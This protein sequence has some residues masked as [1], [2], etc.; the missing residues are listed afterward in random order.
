MQITKQDDLSDLSMTSITPITIS[1]RSVQEKI[2]KLKA[3]KS[4]GSDGISSKTPKAGGQHYCAGT[5]RYIQLQ[6]Q[7]KGSLLF[8]EDGKTNSYF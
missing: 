2:N 5:S 6:Y 3:N 4:T 7:Q 1:E 8:L